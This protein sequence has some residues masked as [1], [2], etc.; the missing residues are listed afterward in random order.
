MMKQFILQS[1]IIAFT[2][3][4]LI[5]CGENQPVHGTGDRAVAAC[6]HQRHQR[7]WPAVS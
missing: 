4:I 2:G 3:L 7:T 6:R 5:S 1:C